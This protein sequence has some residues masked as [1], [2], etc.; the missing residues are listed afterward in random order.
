MRDYYYALGK[1]VECRV[2]ILG[3][4]LGEVSPITVPRTLWETRA[5]S[6]LRGPTLE[7]SG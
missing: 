6:H 2:S 4:L 1:M 5:S 3:G 7:P